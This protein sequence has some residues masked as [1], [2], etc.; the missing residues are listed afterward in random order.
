MIICNTNKSK[1]QGHVCVCTCVCV[2]IHVDV[3]CHFG[4]GEAL[5]QFCPQ[6]VCPPPPTTPPEGV[7]WGRQGWPVPG[8]GAGAF[9]RPYPDGLV[10]RAR[11]LLLAGGL[12]QVR[13]PGRP[14]LSTSSTASLNFLVAHVLVMKLFE[15]HQLPPDGCRALLRHSRGFVRCGKLGA[16]PCTV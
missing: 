2:Y 14:W 7:V 16:G 12:A 5:E 11:G 8:C 6:T 4:S 13:W 10:L 9:A 3:C 15:L 1:F